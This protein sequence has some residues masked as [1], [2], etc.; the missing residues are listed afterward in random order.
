MQSL[1]Q[2]YEQDFISQK[3]QSPAEKGDN[4]VHEAIENLWQVISAKLDA[5]S[6]AHFVPKQVRLFNLSISLLNH[7][8]D[9]QTRE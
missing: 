5:L 7:F 8:L 9:S 3:S 6:N 2:I 1:A 4:K